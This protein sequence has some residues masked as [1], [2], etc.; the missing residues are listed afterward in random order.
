MR[1]LFCKYLSGEL[2][3]AAPK[4][5][6]CPRFSFKDAIPVLFIVGVRNSDSR[7]FQIL[8]QP[9]KENALPEYSILW[10][11]NPVILFGEI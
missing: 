3:Y 11:Q 9:I 8:I 1:F 2:E 4:L 5:Y 6:L 10:L 7:L